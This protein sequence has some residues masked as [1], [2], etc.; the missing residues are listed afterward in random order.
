MGCL[1][2]RY[3]SEAIH[4]KKRAVKY[5][6]ISWGAA[7]A[8]LCLIALGIFAF[9]LFPLQISPGQYRLPNEPED[10]FV[11]MNALLKQDDTGIL[12][13][14]EE[15][16]HIPLSGYQ[17]TYIKIPSLDSDTL[18]Q[19]TGTAVTET[20][21]WYT[22]SGHSDLQYLIQKEEQTYSLWKFKCF[23][24]SAYPYHD[25]LE[26]VYHIDAA[27]QITS[28][29]VYPATMDNTDAGKAVQADIGTHTITDH[30]QI[31]T[32]YQILTSMTCYGENHWNM[33]DDGVTDN[34]ADDNAAGSKAVRLG[35]YITL[36]TDWG[37]EIDGLKYTAVSNMF[38]EFSG[39]AYAPLTANQANRLCNILHIE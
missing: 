2:A 6:W 35:R 8:C 18:S 31:Q 25:V 3:I 1:D 14:V 22:V 28:I 36:V 30:D 37:N 15:T 10:T 9:S 26:L 5:T 12:E 27:D 16:A 11:P 13:T 4:Y 19:S 34:A 24:S 38:Y 20:E 7:T 39:I 21:N 17:A 32:V 23:D 29:Q 33:I